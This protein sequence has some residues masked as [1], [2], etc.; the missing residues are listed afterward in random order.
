V[1]PWDRSQQANSQRNIR[2]LNIWPLPASV[3]PNQ[4]ITLEFRAVG[5]EL[6]LKVNGQLVGTVRDSTY[7]REGEVAVYCKEVGTRVSRIEV[8]NLDG[9]FTTTAAP[10]DS[11]LRTPQSALL[12]SVFTNSVGAEMV[13][14]PSGEFMMGSTKEEQAWAVANGATEASV[15]CE[16]EAP[17]KTRIKDGFWLGR[18][19]VTVGQW[20]KFV[21]ATGYRTDAEKKGYVDNAPRKGQPWGRVD[22]ASWR[23]PGF[24]SPPQDNHPVSCVSWNDAMAFCEWATERERKAGRLADH[25]V[26]LPTEAEWEYACR[27]GVQT[28][29]WWGESKEDGK[30]RLNW[31]GRDDGFEFVAP[32]D[33]YGARGRNGFGLADM[34]GNVYEWCLDDYDAKQ[35]HEEC[36]KGNS[37]ARVLRGGSF[38]FSPAYVRCAYRHSGYAP[39]Y[40]HGS[41][42]FRVCVGLDVSG[43]TTAAASTSP[44]PAPKE[45][46]V[47]APAE[48][49]AAALTANPKRGEVC[50]ISLGSNVT[51][52]LVG[53]PPGEFMLGSTKEEQAWAMAHVKDVY[54]KREGEAPR[55][56]R[57]KDG[58]W[59]GRTEVTVGQWKQFVK[60]TGYVT[61]G[62]KKDESLVPQGAG[63]QLAMWAMKKGVSWRDPNFGFEMRDDHPV[64]CISWNDAV[65]FCEWLTER[66]RKAGRLTAGQGVR[67][68]T[69]AEWEYACRA[70]TQTKFWWGDSSEDGQGRLNWL[71]NAKADGFEFVAPVDSFG[72]RGRNG[73]GLADMLGNVS[74]WCLDEF[75]MT[76][77]HE[78]LWTGYPRLRVLR[79]G[80]YNYGG[81]GNMRCASRHGLSPSS[82]ICIYGF[83]VCVGVNL[84]GGTTAAAS[85]LP[86]RA[87]KATEVPAPA[88]TR[89][90]ALTANP[91][92]GEVCTLPLGGS[93][94]LELVGIPPGEFM[95]G[96]TKEEQAWAVANRAS[97]EE[98]KREGEAPRKAATKQGFWMGRMEVTV[99]QWKQFV[100]ETGYKTDAEKK[101]YVD[102]AP[103]K[104]QPW[105][106]GDGLSWRNPGFGAA[107]QDNH[108]VCGV[109]WNDAMAF[110][111]WATE[112]ERK[113]GRLAA[114]QVV[115]LPT[116]AEWEYA[117]R[118]GTQTKFWWGESEEDGKDRLNWSGK[119][120]GFEFVAP[121]D[122]FGSRGRNGFGLAD[123]LGNVWEW[124]LDEHD[125]KQAHEECYKGN[126]GAR[127]LRGGSFNNYAARARCAHRIS[128]NLSSSGSLT[129][130]RVAVGSLR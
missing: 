74:E 22:G 89:V 43:G 49:R 94:T 13:Y 61:D 90:P 112:R 53:I 122:A 15:N 106:R 97:A 79:G 81:P 91:K 113:A 75:D 58:F 24:G 33:S 44:A 12:G 9:A 93:T 125:A 36:Y 126:P 98:V 70:G 47:Q 76:Q 128:T 11:A 82:S 19:E 129:G 116:E 59:L 3:D 5:D 7:S 124:C 63:N 68:P 32:V 35:A 120:D 16:V 52:E 42:G 26:R 85:T 23:D 40:S 56:T 21:T 87:L 110:C 84:S 65:A 6:S 108:A 73:F 14:I 28:K 92:R 71:G 77:A 20:K 45:T 67:L 117:C 17:R 115:R 86:A 60:E 78:N 31:S 123:M 95:L 27:A 99:G 48:T 127:V 55:K 41:L 119:D 100:K 4:K 64:S 46:E 54:V 10:A 66:E 25:V 96:S 109:S 39:A 34:L 118:A 1:S 130:F 51:M 88:E 102:N 83:R 121:V 37:S 107:P 80:S 62:E 38:I 72:A 57:I 103:Q 8:L 101:G 104:G 2:E 114:G 18:T 50:T 30:D 69:E 111:E 29:F 105:G